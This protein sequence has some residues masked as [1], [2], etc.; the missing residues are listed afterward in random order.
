MKE[1]LQAMKYCIL[2]QILCWGLFIILDENMLTNQSNAETSA[3]F[4]GL[5]L[6]ILILVLYFCNSNKLIKKY[7]LN[8]IKFNVSLTFIWIGLSLITSKFLLDLVDKHVLHICSGWYC[9]LN[10]IEYGLY[11]ILM[12]I[13]VIIILIIKLIIK[14]YKHFKKA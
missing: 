5:G 11:A 3:L 6:L 7:Q 8:S 12:I 2:S 10:G 9:F 1:F 4:V 14:I 13:L